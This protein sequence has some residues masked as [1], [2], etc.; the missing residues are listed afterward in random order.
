MPVLNGFG[1]YQQIRK[2]DYKVKICFLTA[3]TDFNYEAFGKQ[4]SANIDE[5]Y[6]IRKPIENESLI[7]QIK[8]V[9]H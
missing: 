3:T 7:Q 1:L 4:A 9:V 2:F 6:I 5:R 8:S